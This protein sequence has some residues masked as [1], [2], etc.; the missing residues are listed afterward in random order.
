MRRTHKRI[1][2][3]TEQQETFG[4]ELKVSQT[5]TLSHVDHTL[6]SQT[7]TWQDIKQIIDDGIEYGCASVCIPPSYVKRA[8]EYADGRIRICTVIGFPNGYNDPSVKAFEAKVAIEQGASEVD[9]VANLGLIKEGKWE[10]AEADIKEVRLAS[11]GAILKVIV[12]TCL[13][14]DEEISK[15]CKVCADA[16]A[17]YIK[18]STG[19]STGGATFEDVQLMVDNA[20]VGLLVKASGGISDFADAERYLEIGADRLGTSRLVKIAKEG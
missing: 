20:P 17:D 2:E 9:M 7:A 10:E 15:M 14:T 1:R 11:Q 19:F 18:T 4:K 3:K 8:A 13:L 5:E 12:E 16:G 6:L